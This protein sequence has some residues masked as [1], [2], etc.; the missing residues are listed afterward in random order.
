MNAPGLL[1]SLS[2]SAFFGSLLVLQITRVLSRL[3]YSGLAHVS[4]V[5]RAQLRVAVVNIQLLFIYDYY[6]LCNRNF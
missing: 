5:D 4:T 1:R 3:V 2:K 6:S